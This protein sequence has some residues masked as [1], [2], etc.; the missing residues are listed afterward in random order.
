MPI[1]LRRIAD[2]Q[3]KDYLCHELIQKERPTAE[4]IEVK[5]AGS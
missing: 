2:K 5:H 1:L 4:S 3:Q